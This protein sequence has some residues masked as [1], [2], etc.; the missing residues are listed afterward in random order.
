MSTTHHS[1]V[2]G[3]RLLTRRRAR[4]GA[5]LPREMLLVSWMRRA[6]R[7]LRGFVIVAGWLVTC[8]SRRRAVWSDLLTNAKAV[9]AVSARAPGW[10]GRGPAF[11]QHAPARRRSAP[12]G[13][14][15]SAF[16]S[17]TQ[18][19]TVIRQLSVNARGA[20]GSRPLAS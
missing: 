6:M 17:F 4:R 8:N 15:A 1:S 11:G 20:W 16:V 2:L 7:D 19:N 13:E 18:W 14:P 5:G 12:G 3:N 10:R 9:D